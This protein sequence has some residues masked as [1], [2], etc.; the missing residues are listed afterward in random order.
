LRL[1]GAF[2]IPQGDEGGGLTKDASNVGSITIGDLDVWTFEANQGEKITLSMRELTGG[3]SPYLLVYGPTGQL[4][5]YQNHSSL[6]QVSFTA[7][8][9]GLFVVVATSGTLGG[10]GTYQLTNGGLPQQGGFF[11]LRPPP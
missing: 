2:T 11:R 1:P 5:T 8:D 7:P 9:S 10:T 6:A 4:L 3:F